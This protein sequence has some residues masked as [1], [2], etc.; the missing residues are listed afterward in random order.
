MIK[1]YDLEWNMLLADPTSIVFKVVAH[2][3]EKNLKEIIRLKDNT[4]VI[5]VYEIQDNA[6]ARFRISRPLISFPE[7]M[8]KDV[9]RKLRQNETG[10][11]N[12][13]SVIY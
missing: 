12:S 9:E 8:Q 1:V 3:I 13:I 4:S 5:K 2:D 11:V 6:E 10:L 7:G